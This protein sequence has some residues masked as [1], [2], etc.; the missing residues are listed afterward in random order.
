MR[1][2]SKLCCVLLGA[3]VVSFGAA[4]WRWLVG[5]SA[6]EVFLAYTL[7]GNAIFVSVFGAAALLE[8]TFGFRK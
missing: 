8:V 1:N 2:V 6:I 4:V 3:I 7:A 5:A